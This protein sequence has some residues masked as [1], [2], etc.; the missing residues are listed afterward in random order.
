MTAVPGPFPHSFVPESPVD[1]DRLA[2]HF[3]RHRLP[4]PGR[5]LVLQVLQG[6]PVR[7]VGSGAG[8]VVVRYASLKMGRVIQ[9]ESRTVELAF[10]EQCEHDP[11]VLFYLCQPLSLRVWVVDAK[12]RRSRRR[13]VP[14]FLV[15]DD[16]GFALVE[17]KPVSKLEKDASRPSPRFRRD[18]SGWCCPAAQEAAAAFG[19]QHRVFTSDDVN[20]VRVRNMRFLADFLS[21]DS[22]AE[23]ALHLVEAHL[24]KAGSLGARELLAAAQVPADVLWWL[25]AHGRV[26]ADLEQ[27][28]VFSDVSVLHYLARENAREPR[29]SRG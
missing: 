18:A 1:P 8:N 19:L 23:S 16:D 26:F 2:Q 14:D 20:A 17:C 11:R 4:E 6:P 7:R 24:R 28:L 25:V 5:A 22:P 12:G 15:L 27:Q 9:A 21:V 10:V 3:E 13:Y 29:A